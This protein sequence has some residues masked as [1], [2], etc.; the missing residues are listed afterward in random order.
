MLDRFTHRFSTSHSASECTREM[1]LTTPTTKTI[2]D[3]LACC[4]IQANR[5]LKS[6]MR[7]VQ[8]KGGLRRTP[9][10]TFECR[11]IRIDKPKAYF[12]SDHHSFLPTLN[13]FCTLLSHRGTIVRFEKPWQQ[14]R[15]PPQQE[16]FKT[17]LK[18]LSKP[19]NTSNPASPPPPIL[20]PFAQFQ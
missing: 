12:F 1:K 11:P 3:T 20:L 7:K 17:P 18:Q 19:S 5:H 13:F 9:L 4:K 8:S 6:P 15:I 14:S 10:P 2:T 16:A